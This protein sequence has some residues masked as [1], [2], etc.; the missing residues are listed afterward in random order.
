MILQ[1]KILFKIIKENYKWIV[2]FICLVILD[3][4][5][6]VVRPYQI[7]LSQND[8][9]SIIGFPNLNNSFISILLYIYQFCFLLYI[10]YVF[11]KDD[12]E[13]SFENVILRIDS[14]KWITNKIIILCLF[15][16]MCKL[17]QV[18]I[19]YACFFNKI[20]WSFKYLIYSILISLLVST[21]VPFNLNFPKKLHPILIVMEIVVFLY[22]FVNI[23]SI[24]PY[25]VIFGICFYNINYFNFK[26]TIE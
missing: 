8:F 26:K 2:L 12:F 22:S 16:V 15:I 6:L 4:I 5:F 25:I 20:E 18:L 21:F 24:F 13:H 14:K 3:Y 9:Y 7:K 17:F 11:F 10:S 23:N 1:L 19:I